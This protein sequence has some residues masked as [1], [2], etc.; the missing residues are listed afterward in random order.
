M[1]WSLKRQAMD[2]QVL[3]N[4]GD[5][6]ALS[7]IRAYI[8]ARKK[9]KSRNKWKRKIR[10]MKRLLTSVAAIVLAVTLV[11]CKNS[12][13][14]VYSLTTQNIVSYGLRNSPNTAGYLRDV[15]PV[16]CA[17]ANGTNLTP[18]Q[19]VTAIQ[20]SGI[21]DSAEGKLIM[22]SVLIVFISAYDGLGANTNASA[23][24][25]YAQAIFCDGFE[26]GLAGAPSSKARNA[27][28]AKTVWPLLKR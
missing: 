21:D 4:A 2:S 12:S 6:T 1:K 16:V 14:L 19:I 22:N 8:A 11:G 3:A 17:A 27:P 15:Q 23:V 28:P 24:Q 20:S 25:P 9:T 26:W 5:E 7:D 13:P 10:T 18:A